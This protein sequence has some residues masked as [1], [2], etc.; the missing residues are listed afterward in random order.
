M[1]EPPLQPPQMEIG[2]PVDSLV[3]RP[4]GVPDDT[5]QVTAGNVVLSDDRTLFPFSGGSSA[6]FSAL[7]GAEAS[8]WDLL[9]LDLTGSTPVLSII[10]GTPALS[11]QNWW[12]SVPE[13]PA[14][15]FPLAAVHITEASPAPVVIETDDVVDVR[16]YFAS[17]GGLN[18]S[19]SAGDP[20]DWINPG[21]PPDNVVDAVD[22]LAARTRN[23]AETAATQV[24]ASAGALG[25]SKSASRADHVHAHGDLS[26]VAADHHDAPQIVYSPAVP[27]DWLSP[28]DQVGEALDEVAARVE[29]FSTSITADQVG[30]TPENAGNWSSSPSDVEDALDQLA[31]HRVQRAFKVLGVSSF[32]LST[33][34]YTLTSSDLVG[35]SA[36][37]YGTAVIGGSVSGTPRDLFLRFN[38]DTGNNYINSGISTV[39]R[40]AIFDGFSALTGQ[41]IYFDVT[42][43]PRISGP[44]IVFVRAIEY[45]PGS[46]GFNVRTR[47]AVW[48]NPSLAD[49]ASVTVGI[50][51]ST[52]Y[53]F[54]LGS[55]VTVFRTS[56]GGL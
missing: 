34:E 29:A 13:V 44:I 7:S 8:R 16:G 25:S 28:P 17:V 39:N 15:T 35:P 55:R 1:A 22:E 21:S 43:I 3:A 51:G 9:T 47:N 10:Q 42:F 37:I 12:D 11:A 53:N 24:H 4:Q 32:L 50:P 41:A 19:Y 14:G 31:G 2:P 38:E 49:L 33:K 27:G 26:G 20:D 52:G 56:L 18:I 5:I 46:G 40:I 30:Y 48:R 23:S 54:G 45:N 6:A 36:H